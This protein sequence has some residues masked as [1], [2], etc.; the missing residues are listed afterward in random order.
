MNKL[1]ANVTS[2][3]ATKNTVLSVSCRATMAPISSS[4]GGGGLGFDSRSH[5]VLRVTMMGLSGK[6]G[7]ELRNGRFEKGLQVLLIERCDMSGEKRSRRYE[8]CEVCHFRDEGCW[9]WR[10]G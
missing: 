2:A 4:G 5:S 10:E 6:Q 9:K 3:V 7:A 8:D 1:A